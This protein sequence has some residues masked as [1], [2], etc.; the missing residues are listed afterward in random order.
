MNFIAIYITAKDI[1]Q[2]KVIGRKLVEERLVACVN[3]IPAIES[4]YWWQGAICSDREAIIIAKTKR[5]LFDKV[6]Q[7]VKELHSYEVPCIVSYPIEKGNQEYLDW[8]E[9]ET[10]G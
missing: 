5:S 10:N 2:A 1:D 6:E 7:R 9:H 4:M 8:I 3:I